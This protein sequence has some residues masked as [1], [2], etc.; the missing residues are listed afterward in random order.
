M[1][2]SWVTTNSLGRVQTVESD[3]FAPPEADLTVLRSRPAMCYRQSRP[4]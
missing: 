4:A 3:P 2:E 1:S